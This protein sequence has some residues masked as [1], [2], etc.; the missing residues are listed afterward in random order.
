[1]LVPDKLKKRIPDKG[2]LLTDPR[3]YHLLNEQYNKSLRILKERSECKS[4]CVVYDALS[5]FMC[6]TD[7]Q[8]AIQYIRHN[9]WWEEANKI[10]SVYIHRLNTIQNK[11][12]DEYIIWFA[13]SVF[14][15]ENKEKKSTMKVRGL[16]QEPRSYEI[17]YDLCIVNK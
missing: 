13:N 12:F 1:M 16:F 8:I 15:L 4:L 5:D 6:F 9:M 2:Y 11:F 14:Y 7:E 10:S 3:D 17:D